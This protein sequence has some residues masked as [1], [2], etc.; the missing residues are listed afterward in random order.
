MG[1]NQ[2]GFGQQ[3][4]QGGQFG[5]QTGQIIVRPLS[6]C[7]T[8]DLDFWTK[9]DPFCEFRYGQ[10]IHKSSVHQEGGKTPKW[11]DVLKFNRTNDT[12]I[13][14]KVQ[15]EDITSNDLVGDGILNLGHAF[16]SAGTQVNE[17]VQLTNKGKNTGTVLISV[18]FHPQGW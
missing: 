13:N 5:L 1:G 18:E 9:M 14:V 6:G 8:E 17:T 16:S 12:V 7:F 4:N 10:Q 2:G 3:P 15:D 11:N